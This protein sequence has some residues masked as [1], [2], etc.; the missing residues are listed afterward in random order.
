MEILQKPP[1]GSSIFAY[2]AVFL[3]AAPGGESLYRQATQSL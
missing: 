2:I 1:G 3:G